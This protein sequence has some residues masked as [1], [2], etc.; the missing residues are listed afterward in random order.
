MIRFFEVWTQWDINIKWIYFFLQS[1]PSTTLYW[2]SFSCPLMKPWTDSI[3]L[4]SILVIKTQSSLQFQSQCLICISLPFPFSISF[5]SD[6]D[7]LWVSGQGMRE[8][9]LLCS[10]FKTWLFQSI[11]MDRMW[12]EMD[13]WPNLSLLPVCD[14]VPFCRY[15]LVLLLCYLLLTIKNF[16]K[17]SMEFLSPLWACFSFAEIQWICLFT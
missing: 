7:N 14:W 1:L 8:M 3:S 9:F 2:I 17:K 5:N 10:C 13:I 12:G 15:W 11:K 16:C 6:P 4:W